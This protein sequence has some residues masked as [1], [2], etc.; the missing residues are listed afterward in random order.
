[1]QHAQRD[2]ESAGLSQLSPQK[3]AAI[4]N[5][6]LK[7]CGFQLQVDYTVGDGNCL[8]HAII[9]QYRQ[10]YAHAG[11]PSCLKDHNTLRAALVAAMRA[12]PLPAEIVL[13]MRANPPDDGG[14]GDQ[15]YTDVWEEMCNQ[16]STPG[17]WLDQYHVQYLQ[18]LLDVP[19]IV[20]HAAPPQQPP[21]RFPDLEADHALHD[22]PPLVLGFVNQIHYMT[23]RP[24]ASA[25]EPGP[26]R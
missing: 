8:L 17:S 2:K 11:A 18:E 26:V 21:L 12:N 20:V 13:A 24:L 1:M 4:L 5:R 19:I 22:K 16:T 14:A 15:V 25:Y 6:R 7:W 3:Q 9:D 10:H 23:T